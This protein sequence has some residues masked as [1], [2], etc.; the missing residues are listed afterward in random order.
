MKRY[1]ESLSLLTQ[2]LY[3]INYHFERE[4]WYGMIDD[5]NSMDYSDAFDQMM[6]LFERLL[7]ENLLP[8]AAHRACDANSPNDYRRKGAHQLY[9]LGLL[10]FNYPGQEFILTKNIIGGSGFGVLSGGQ[11]EG[12]QRVAG[13]GAVVK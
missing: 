5:F 4:Q 7:H 10:G 13:G 11:K 1:A 6:T 9:S 12:C 8:D 3:T 2:M